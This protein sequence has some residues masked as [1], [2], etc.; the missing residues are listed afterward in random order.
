LPSRPA[1][2]QQIAI[3]PGLFRLEERH[4]SSAGHKTAVLIQDAHGIPEA[5]ENIRRTIEMLGSQYHFDLVTLEGGAGR[6]DHT[7]F[8]AF[9]DPAVTERRVLWYLKRGEL[10]GG[11]AA[12]VLSPHRAVFYGLEDRE[13]YFENRRAFLKALEDRDSNLQPL[14]IL[15][16]KLDRAARDLYPADL[17][18]FHR[19]EE[20]F[21]E[22][23]RTLIDFL[24]VIFEFS[25]RGN[26]G[27]ESY[28]ALTR[29]FALFRKKTGSPKTASKEIKALSGLEGRAVFEEMEKMSR[30]IKSRYFG[31]GSERRALD[32]L[33]A[34]LR[35][36][37]RLVSLEASREDYEECRRSR[38]I[39]DLQPFYAFLERGASGRNALPKTPF[40]PG[41]A[42]LFY[43]GAVKRDEPMY[44]NFTRALKKEN[45]DGAVIVTG[46]F[47]T[48]GLTERLRRDGV[49]YLVLS[50]Q[51]SRIPKDNPYFSVIRNRVSYRA[52]ALQVMLVTM[53]LQDPEQQAGFYRS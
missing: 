42:L 23:R 20:A 48:A 47:H 25:S 36:I 32:A 44:R 24:E 39:L 45:R 38:D 10:S 14:R 22:D 3:D 13:L 34:R 28:P 11:E 16:K 12:A 50:P 8:R 35:L 29:L 41:W 6:A 33:F 31:P 30:E 26:I 9:P 46:G 15:H 53:G 2:V 1:S 5:Q 4:L 19:K 7:L 17:Y 49:S 51:F 40:D 52:S 37:R 21:L 43:E 18:R 27:T